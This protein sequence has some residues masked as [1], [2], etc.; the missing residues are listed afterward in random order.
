MIEHDIIIHMLN[1]QGGKVNIQ[2]GMSVHHLSEWCPIMSQCN[3]LSLMSNK[4]WGAL[5]K[6]SASYPSVCQHGHICNMKD[7]LYIVQGP[8]GVRVCTWMG[9]VIKWPN[10]LHHTCHALYKLHNILG[11]SMGCPPKDHIK[12]MKINQ[13]HIIKLYAIWQF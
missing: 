13:S 5:S 8:R 2:G 12:C 1:V 4:L 11:E 6:M 9:Q 3:I 10:V 7:H